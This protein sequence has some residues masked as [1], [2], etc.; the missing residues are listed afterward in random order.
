MQLLPWDADLSLRS[1]NNYGK[2]I[3]NWSKCFRTWGRKQLWNISWVS[4]KKFIAAVGEP[5]YRCLYLPGAEA[6]H[7]PLEAFI[8]QLS[9]LGT[10]EIQAGLGLSFDEL[11]HHLRA[12]GLRQV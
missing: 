1:G 8:G 9:F 3:L 10:Q 4:W 11:L 7:K 6:E 2:K 5:L 12:E